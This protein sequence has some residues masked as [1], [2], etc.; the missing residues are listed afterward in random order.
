M[1]L[2]ASKDLDSVVAWHWQ[3]KRLASWH[4][5]LLGLIKVIYCMQ[6]PFI[7]PEDQSARLSSF[8]VTHAFLSLI[9]KRERRITVPNT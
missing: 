8:H 6:H 5:I 2:L 3:L 1:R 7:F 4:E 9:R